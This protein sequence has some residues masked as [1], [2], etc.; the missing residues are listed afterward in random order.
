MSGVA[1]VDRE[2]LYDMTDEF[3]T[4][5]QNF[6]PALIMLRFLLR[7]GIRGVGEEDI[8]RTGNIRSSVL[9]FQGNVPTI[10]T[11]DSGGLGGMREKKQNAGVS[12]TQGR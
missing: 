4:C 1:D 5:T 8:E 6:A 9:Q 2:V 7:S 12:N 11:F 3:Y 10:S